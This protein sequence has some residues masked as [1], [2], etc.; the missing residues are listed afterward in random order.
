MATLYV[1]GDNGNDGNN[2]S[3][4]ALAKATIQDAVDNASTGDTIYVQNNG[5]TVYDEQVTITDLSMTLIGYGSTVDDETKAVID[6]EDT[7]DYCITFTNTTGTPD[8][9]LRNFELK[10]ATSHGLYMN[11]TSSGVNSIHRVDNVYSHDNGGDGFH[12]NWPND[13]PGLYTRCKATLNGGRGFYNDGT[14][15]SMLPVLCEAIDN[16]GA[17]FSG[18]SI[19]G[20]VFVWCVAHG[21]SNN[22]EASVLIGCTSDLADSDGWVAALNTNTTAIACGFSNNGAYGIDGAPT[23]L[24][25]IACGFYNNTSGDTNPTPAKNIDAV[26]GSDP[27]YTDAANEDFT[28][29]SS[30]PWKQQDVTVGDPDDSKLSYPDIGAMQINVTGGGSGG[31]SLVNSGLVSA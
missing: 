13:T 26:T 20:M 9:T 1:D 24:D 25:L 6:G 3:S 11:R 17:G 18:S 5:S 12:H 8:F 23:L 28:L 14:T 31:G 16:V 30:S 29:G 22:F 7:R 15:G 2:G 27:S 21:N 4:E 10:Q 19:E